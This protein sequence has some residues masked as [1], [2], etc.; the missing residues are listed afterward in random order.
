[1]DV[2]SKRVVARPPLSEHEGG[3]GLG[4]VVHGGRAAD[5]DGGPAVAPQ[6]VLQ[7]ASHLAVPVWDVA[8]LNRATHT[9]IYLFLLLAVMSNLREIFL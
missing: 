8:F 9:M 5:D 3:L 7:D 1:M 6:G 4:L 2:G